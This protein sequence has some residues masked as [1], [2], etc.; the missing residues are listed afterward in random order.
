MQKNLIEQLT[1]DPEKDFPIL[2]QIWLIWKAETNKGKEC[3]SC[4]ANKALEW[5]TKKLK[6]K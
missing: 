3:F 2:K 4:T 1:G 6:E 5:L